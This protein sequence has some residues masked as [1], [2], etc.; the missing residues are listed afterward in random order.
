ME[1]KNFNECDIF[2]Y[3]QLPNKEYITTYIKE[4]VKIVMKKL[5]KEKV[6][7]IWNYGLMIMKSMKCMY[8]ILE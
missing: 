5:K 4:K 2:L 8:H 1:N 7:L 3:N 6:K